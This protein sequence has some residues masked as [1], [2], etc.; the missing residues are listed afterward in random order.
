MTTVHTLKYTLKYTYHI[1][2]TKQPGLRSCGTC[3]DNHA[4]RAPTRSWHESTPTCCVL[5]ALIVS[6]LHMVQKTTP[7]VSLVAVAV[8]LVAAAVGSSLCWGDTGTTA[9]HWLIGSDCVA[10]K[11]SPTLRVVFRGPGIRQGYNPNF[12]RHLTSAALSVP[13]RTSLAK[14][15][16]SDT[17][18][19]MVFTG[20]HNNQDQIWLV[21]IGE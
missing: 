11:V 21:K 4:R 7:V 8:F 17:Q 19:H 1:G 13:H 16:T 14:C 12:L 6:L 18:S 2:R 20:V 3:P 5:A 10:V 15:D 9:I